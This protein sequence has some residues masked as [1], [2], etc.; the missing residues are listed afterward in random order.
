[1]DPDIALCQAQFIL[2]ALKDG[3]TV[4]MNE[5]KEL[6]FFKER[7]ETMK[8]NNYSQIFL[9]KYGKLGPLKPS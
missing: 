1:M 8:Q 7:T 6:K 2:N 9:E 4:K 3:W 5:K